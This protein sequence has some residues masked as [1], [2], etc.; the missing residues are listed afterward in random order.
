MYVHKYIHTHAC[1]QNKNLI[2]LFSAN[3]LRKIPPLLEKTTQRN[4][5]EITNV[6]LVR[7]IV[8]LI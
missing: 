5:A 2:Q 4:D 3:E 8:D 7:L 6:T 1:E